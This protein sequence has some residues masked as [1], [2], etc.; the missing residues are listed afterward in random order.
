[1]ALLN[2]WGRYPFKWI[3]IF[4][5]FIL[6]VYIGNAGGTGRN[7]PQTGIV[8]GMISIFSLTVLWRTRYSL[9]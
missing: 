1:M 9:S 4:T 2:V 8:W 6:Q 5:L 3:Y 7:L